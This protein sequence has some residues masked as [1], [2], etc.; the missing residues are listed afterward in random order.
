MRLSCD[1]STLITLAENCLLWLLRDFSVAGTSFYITPV[2]K[3]EIIDHP[4]RMKRFEFEAY[5]IHKL[6]DD[7]HLKLFRQPSL[8]HDTKHILK[9]ANQSFLSKH[10]PI[11]LIHEGEAQILALSSTMDKYVAIDEKTTRLLIEDPKKLRDILETKSNYRIRVDGT[12]LKK[13][14][15]LTSGFKVIRSSEII[16]VAYERGMLERYGKGKKILN[17][18]LWGLRGSGCAI[19]K[20][21]I[22]QLSA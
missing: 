21:E 6:L 7:G 13:F 22:E 14:N 16:S 4:L 2:V 8:K 20:Q 11:N 1:S 9:L 5:K 17:A 3:D 15:K 19:T 10:G 12:I 18:A